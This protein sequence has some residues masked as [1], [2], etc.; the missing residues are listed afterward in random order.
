M[1]GL[2]L[3]CSFFVISLWIILPL[4]RYLIKLLPPVKILYFRRATSIQIR[5]E[6]NKKI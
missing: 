5:L 4:W 1:E 3:V 6:V 2:V